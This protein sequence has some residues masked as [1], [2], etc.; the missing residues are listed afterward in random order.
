MFRNVGHHVT[1]VKIQYMLRRNIDL[2]NENSGQN[3]AVSSL[4][5]HQTVL[6]IWRTSYVVI[7][8]I[9]CSKINRPH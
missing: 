2:R 8:V 4:V 5:T 3:Y 1:Q 6:G 9:V 7:F